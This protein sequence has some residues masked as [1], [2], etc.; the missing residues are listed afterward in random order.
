[1]SSKSTEK[2]PISTFSETGYIHI[3]VYVYGDK[4]SKLYIFVI[5]YIF[6]G[7]YTCIML[8]FSY[9]SNTV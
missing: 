6:Y 7:I 8:S 3:F 2:G 5:I 9:I 1:M 4:K